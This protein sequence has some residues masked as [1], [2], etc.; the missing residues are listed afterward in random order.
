MHNRSQW[1]YLTKDS[2]IEYSELVSVTAITF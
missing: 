2:Q 1:A